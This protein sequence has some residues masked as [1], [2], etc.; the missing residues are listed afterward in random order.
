[1]RVLAKGLKFAP[2]HRK[3][4][5]YTSAIDRVSRTIRLRFHFGLDTSPPERPPFTAKS[6]WMPP[7][8]PEHVEHYIT[9]A[10]N[11]KMTMHNVFEVVLRS[12]YMIILIYLP[13]LYF[14]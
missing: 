1:M 11:A 14:L 3:Q 5:D 9:D 8:A 7:R 10:I 12:K 2:S 4:T 13:N 6:A